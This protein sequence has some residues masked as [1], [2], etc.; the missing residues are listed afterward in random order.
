MTGKKGKKPAAGDTVRTALP[1]QVGEKPFLCHGANDLS[2]Q[3]KM[4]TSSAVMKVL[5]LLCIGN[6]TKPTH[7]EVKRFLDNGVHYR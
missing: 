6:S 7:G 4:Q 1:L 5:L 3:K 2:T